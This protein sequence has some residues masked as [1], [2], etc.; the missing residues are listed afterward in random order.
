MDKMEMGGGGGWGWG[1][2]QSDKFEEQAVAWLTGGG[3][4]SG[5][6]I[7]LKRAFEER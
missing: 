4:W 6:H 5:P 2:G 1:W 7:S 3:G